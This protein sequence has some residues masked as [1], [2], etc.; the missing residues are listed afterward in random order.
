MLTLISA[1][2]NEGDGWDARDSLPA[3]PE[4]LAMG[5][6]G[7]SGSPKSI[8]GGRSLWTAAGRLL[9]PLKPSGADLTTAAD[10]A[11]LLCAAGDGCVGAV[12]VGRVGVAGGPGSNAAAAADSPA[13][14]L[15]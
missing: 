15:G 9:T 6:S 2:S 13:G 3:R 12:G 7:L 5:S 11:L 10:R 14:G 1:S 8:R 4:L